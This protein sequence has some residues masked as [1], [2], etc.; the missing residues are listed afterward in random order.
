MKISEI[1]NYLEQF[2]PKSLQ[3]SYDN[4]GLIVGNPSKEISSALI[5]LDSLEAIIDE[6]IE[7]GSELIIAH[8]PI[9][10]KGLKSIT[11]K[12]Y[13]ER[14]ILKAIKNDIAIYAFH[15]NL[16]NIKLGVNLKIGQKIGLNNLQILKPKKGILQKLVFFSPTEHTEKIRNAIFEAGAGEIGNYDSCSFSVSGSGTFRA[17][18][19]AEPFVG[20]KGEI[21]KEEENRIEFIFPAYKKRNIINAL[22]ENHPYEEVAY[23]VYALENEFSEVGSGMIGDLPVEMAMEDFLDRLKINLKL[24]CIRHTTLIKEKVSKVAFCGGSG[25]FLLNDAIAQGADVFVSADFKY[26]QFFDANNRIVI[27]DIGHYESEQYTPE[28]IQDYLKEKIPNFATYLS[29]VNTNP[30]NYR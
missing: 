26:H 7:Q 28:I 3:E 13:I 24:D 1:I 30:I 16:D 11:G 4:S 14:I 21:H 25:S 2:A 9:V 23:D 20:K 8:H 29:K 5:C 27:A 15:T 18:N 22:K 6:A 12:N 17:G 19:D 10:F